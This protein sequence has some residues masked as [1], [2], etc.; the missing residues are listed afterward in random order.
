M[1][2]CRALHARI[3]AS[4]GTGRIPAEGQLGKG[5]P[6]CSDSG[7][8]EAASVLPF[9]RHWNSFTGNAVLPFILSCQWQMIVKHACRRHHAPSNS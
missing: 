8:T 6:N 4:T 7:S 9:Q 2:K 5:W 3:L 1:H